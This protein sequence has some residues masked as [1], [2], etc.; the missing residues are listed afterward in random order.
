M[1]E[2][3]RIINLDKRQVIDPKLLGGSDDL[4]SM[5][6]EKSV[7]MGALLHLLNPDIPGCWGGDRI[8]VVSNTPHS[9]GQI[10]YQERD[11]LLAYLFEATQNTNSDL[12]R[13][14]HVSKKCRE[15]MT[16]FYGYEFTVTVTEV[17]TLRRGRKPRSER[18]S[19]TS[20]TRPTKEVVKEVTK[21]DPKEASFAAEVPFVIVNH[22]RHEMIDPTVLDYSADGYA[23]EAPM[24]VLAGA[25]INPVNGGM[26]TLLGTLLYVEGQSCDYPRA[27]RYTGSWAG[28]RIEVL[29]CEEADA[30]GFEDITGLIRMDYAH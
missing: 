30:Q 25:V 7:A 1:S 8:V 15:E 4:N 16:E 13:F 17:E 22:D 12:P 14:S 9:I 3:Y 27:G 21:I 20:F 26:G 28:Q 5:L 23:V 29:A 10:P 2:R 19:R 24:D 6:V 11:I 18:G